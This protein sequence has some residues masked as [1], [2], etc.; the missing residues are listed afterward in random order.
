MYF[1]ENEIFC[2]TSDFAIGPKKLLTQNNEPFSTT[3]HYIFL[4]G[5]FLCGV[6]RV[7]STKFNDIEQQKRIQYLLKCLR[8]VQKQKPTKILATIGCFACM[9][10]LSVVILPVLLGCFIYREFILRKIKVTRLFRLLILNRL[11]SFILISEQISKSFQR[12]T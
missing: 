5:L 11:S 2:N 8:C 6:L 1:V 9:L 12:I 3:A 7:F 10:L 4:T